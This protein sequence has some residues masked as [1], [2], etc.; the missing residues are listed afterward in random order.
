MEHEICSKEFKKLSDAIDSIGLEV[1][2]ARAQ[3]VRFRANCQLTQGTVSGIFE[4]PKPCPTKK[5]S[6]A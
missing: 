5:K 3:T 1:K 4:R 2:D 6:V